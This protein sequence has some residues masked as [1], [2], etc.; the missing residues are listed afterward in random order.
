M[1]AQGA[2]ATAQAM[3][4]P[5]SKKGMGGAPCWR[6]ADDPSH[7]KTPVWLSA[8]TGSE[9]FLREVGF[10][11]T[12]PSVAGTGPTRLV[13]GRQRPVGLRPIGHGR[14]HGGRVPP[15]DLAAI[16]RLEVLGHPVRDTLPLNRHHAASIVDL[17]GTRTPCAL[18]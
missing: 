18:A 8:E 11:P 3:I 12:G 16:E 4:R 13:H 17:I 14:A 7:D 1:N 10:E 6:R 2:R 5:V 9:L 15:D